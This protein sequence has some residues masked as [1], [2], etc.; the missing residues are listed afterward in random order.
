MFGAAYEER[1]HELG[2][3]GQFGEVQPRD[4]L[5]V[6]GACFQPGKVSPETVVRAETECDVAIRVTTD[7]ELVRTS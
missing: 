7:I 4:Q 2:F 5:V 3:A 6:E 1:L